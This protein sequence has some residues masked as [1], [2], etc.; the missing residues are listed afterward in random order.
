MDG[1]FAF[2]TGIKLAST[3]LHRPLFGR[4]KNL[5]FICGTAIY[6]AHLIPAVEPDKTKVNAVLADHVTVGAG[7]HV[8]I[9]DACVRPL[10]IEFTVGTESVRGIE[11]D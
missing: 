5:C 6:Q 7:L 3:S 2:A 11:A 10:I 8:Y 1:Q 9:V 4:R